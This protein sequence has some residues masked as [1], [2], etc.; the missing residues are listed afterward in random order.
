MVGAIPACAMQHRVMCLLA[1]ATGGATCTV[2]GTNIYPIA[3]EVVRGVVIRDINP[4]IV[5]ALCSS[6]SRGKRTTRERHHGD[7]EATRSQCG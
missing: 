4:P 7:S 1:L 2:S 6:R 3:L 5:W